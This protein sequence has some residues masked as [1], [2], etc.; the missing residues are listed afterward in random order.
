LEFREI[1]APRHRRPLTIQL[2]GQGLC[3]SVPPF[4]NTPVPR[5]SSECFISGMSFSSPTIAGVVA[6]ML[7]KRRISA[8]RSAP[9]EPGVRGSS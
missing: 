3:R 9:V 5:Y 2:A 6:L 1:P 8:D 4:L 7:Q